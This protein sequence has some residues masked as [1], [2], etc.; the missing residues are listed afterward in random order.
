V[1]DVMHVSVQ[2]IVERL[3]VARAALDSASLASR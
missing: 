1:L 3:D 2:N